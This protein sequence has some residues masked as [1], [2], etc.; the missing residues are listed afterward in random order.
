MG[1]CFLKVAAIRFQLL[2]HVANVASD[3]EAVA[4]IWKEAQLFVDVNVLQSEGR[5]TQV[6]VGVDVGVEAY[7]LLGHH[8]QGIEATNDQRRHQIETEGVYHPT[9]TL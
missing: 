4:A 5:P 9:N 3:R 2:H 8:D 1:Q 6:A 7:L